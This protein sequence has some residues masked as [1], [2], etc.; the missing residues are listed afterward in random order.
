MYLGFS[1]LSRHFKS[2]I[3]PL[4]QVTQ[5]IGPENSPI[6]LSPGSKADELANAL[7]AMDSAGEIQKIYLQYFN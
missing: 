5:P 3:N 2:Q 6:M 7:E 4:F 1:K